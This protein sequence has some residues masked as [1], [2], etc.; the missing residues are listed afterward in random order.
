MI[1]T[2][3]LNP[4]LDRVIWVDEMKTDDSI[5]ISQEKHYAGGKGIDSSRVIKT[6]GGETTA[7]GFLGSFNGLH[8]EGL[9]INEGVTCDFVKISGETRSNVII[10]NNKSKGHMAFNSKGPEITPYDL[11]RLF[12]K[13]NDLAIKPSFVIL[14]GSLPK[15]L[16]A[17]LYAQLIHSFKQQGIKVALDSDNE[18]LKLG[19]KEKPYLI[20]PNSHEFARL[21]G[22]EPKTEKE[23]V[24][25]GR[26]LIKQGLEMVIIS[27]GPDGLLVLDG[28]D[29]FQIISPKVE[30]K[31]TIG[32]G[33][34]ALAAFILG[35][36]NGKGLDECG[37]MAAAAGAGTAMSDG[38]ELVSKEDYEKLLPKA[39]YRKLAV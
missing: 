3:T 9:L 2:V 29:A 26:E 27:R 30:V 15:G 11:A 34:S 19:I 38:V 18:P 25:A 17:N 12:N 23:Y 22:F 39:E 1:L 28:K 33:D 37:A 4:S 14:S 16:N 8:L 10:F 32:S 20:K 31:S 24:S 21:V 6:L 5:R 13:L 7:T 35:L 36:E